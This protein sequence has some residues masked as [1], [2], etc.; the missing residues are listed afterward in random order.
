MQKYFKSGK[1][2]MSGLST[3]RTE[4]ALEHEGGRPGDLTILVAD[5]NPR[6]RGLVERELRDAGYRVFAVDSVSQLRS[7]IAPERLPD[8]LILDPD[9]PGG[10]PVDHIWPLLRRY[11]RLPV[12][13]HCLGTDI[14]GPMPRMAFTVIVEKSADS[15]DLLKRQIVLLLRK[16]HQD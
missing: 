12:V 8:L 10:G 5:R 3:D 15:I 4:G 14:P 13:F 2:I 16:K 1:N 9:L 6:I 11:P 7:W